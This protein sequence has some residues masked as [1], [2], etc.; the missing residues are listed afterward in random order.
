MKFLFTFFFLLTIFIYPQQ[1]GTI[2]LHSESSTRDIPIYKREG[3]IY[4]EAKALSEGLQISYSVPS[5]G[6]IVLKGEQNDL[7]ITAKNPYYVISSKK[8]E[9]ERTFQLSTSTYLFSG[10]IYIPLF[11]SAELLKDLFNKEIVYDEEKKFLSLKGYTHIPANPVHQPA[12]SVYHIS[13]LNIDE[14]ANGTLVTIACSK[15][16]KFYSSTFD[17]NVLTIT[18]RGVNIDPSTADRV[19]L[20]GL[21]KNLQVINKGED[22]EINF[23][24]SGDYSASEMLNIDGSNNLLLTLH[25]RVFAGR[26]QNRL[27]DK[28][29]FDVI[30]LDA[31]HGGKDAGAIGV[32]GV[33]E[34]D[35]N[36]TITLML[37]KMIEEKLPGLKVEY[38][39][40]DD[41]FV[42]LF[43]RGRIA[44]EKH[45]KLFISIHCNSTPKK[46]SDASGFEVY[47]LR[48]GRTQ[49]AI[50]IAERENSV[51]K[52]EEDPHRYQQLTDENFIL[53]SMAHSAYMKYSEKFSEY[54]DKHFGTGFGLSN[55]GVKQAGFYVLVGAS[56]PGVL[57]EAG[58]LSNK[59]DAE[60]LSSK[61]GQE[62]TAELI[63]KSIKS[64]KE[65]YESFLGFDN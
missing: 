42:E 37:G 7:L 40:K 21:I 59:K 33:K 57:V 47:L 32:N 29:D 34:K 38:T 5:E 56:M 1:S 13:S 12:A 36:L 39:R 48:P 51:I 11:Y 65:Y 58:F 44:N 22:S 17:D 18:L 43:K 31:G 53:V 52:Y 16:V 24:V 3:T 63:F 14:K 2:K 50:S 60:Y 55:R 8:G 46:N 9:F 4:A 35:I 27:K 64:Y 23:Y 26:D 19:A 20:R 30:V 45:G 28:W 49:E 25:N 62:K 54:L 6:K 15:E 10:E 41:S 61:K